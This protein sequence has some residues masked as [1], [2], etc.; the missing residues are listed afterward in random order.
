MMP[1]EQ[2][3]DLINQ[4]CGL[5]VNWGK[6]CVYYCMATHKLQ[7]IDWMP[8][9]QLL[10]PPGSGKTQLIKLLIRL[11]YRPYPITCHDRMT[12]TTLRNMLEKARNR[13]AI[14]EEGDLYPNRT[15]IERYL[16]NRA[17]TATSALPFTHQKADSQ[18]A[19]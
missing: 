13:T 19:I 16:I 8:A 7:F 11:V 9:L 10:A 18:G 3:A 2:L 1:V 6:T 12:S 14:I 4:V 5:V 17:S 15:E